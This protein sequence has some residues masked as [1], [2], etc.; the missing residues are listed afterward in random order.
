M[1]T[2]KTNSIS[3]QELAESQ[4]SQAKLAQPEGAGKAEQAT[5]AEAPKLNPLRVELARL[6]HELFDLS[7]NSRRDSRQA[8][9][10]PT[11][12]EFMAGRADAYSIAARMLM[13]TLNREDL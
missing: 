4:P 3:R 11:L 2:N 10:D 5:A 12:R 1:K 6:V 9:L 7:R 8:A 13:A